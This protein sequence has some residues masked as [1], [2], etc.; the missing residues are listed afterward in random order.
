MYGYTITASGRQAGVGQGGFFTQTVWFTKPGANPLT[1]RFVYDCGTSS[2]KKPLEREIDAFASHLTAGDVVDVIYISH[3]DEDHANR[4]EYLADALAK[5]RVTVSR[6]VAPYLSDLERNVLVLGRRGN[7]AWR[8]IVLNPEAELGE[9]FPGSAITILRASPPD[10]PTRPEDPIPRDEER[11]ASTD[12]DGITLRIDDEGDGSVRVRAS[13]RASSA[14]P[15]T[16]LWEVVPHMSKRALA[17]ASETQSQLQAL[18]TKLLHPTNVF[19]G[20]VHLLYDP[21]PREGVRQILRGLLADGPNLSS[22]SVY[23]GCSAPSRD[24]VASFGP[25]QWRSRWTYGRGDDPSHVQHLGWLGTGD[26]RFSDDD[27]DDRSALDDLAQFFG[28]RLKRLLVVNA[29]HHGS[30]HSSGHEFWDLVSP[31]VAVFNASGRQYGHP[32]PHV[33]KI[34][35]DNGAWAVRTDGRGHAFDFTVTARV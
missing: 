16:V 20:L 24:Y 28:D 14:S 32:S 30:V 10:D 26:A 18:L 25:R 29:P 3:F 33:E 31:I 12:P 15:D 5:Q 9:L 23:S 4:I 7:A 21:G 34:A 19:S 11:G 6:V 1:F 27:P 8:R 22:I 17:I 2:G 13:S 35:Q